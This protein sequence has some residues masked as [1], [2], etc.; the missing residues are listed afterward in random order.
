[1]VRRCRIIDKVAIEVLTTRSSRV[2]WKE[3]VDVNL[4]SCVIG[5]QTL[6]YEVGAV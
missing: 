5:H 1:M 6:H 4:S 3:R 2:V